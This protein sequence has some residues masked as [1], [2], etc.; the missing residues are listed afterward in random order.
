MSE[1]IGQP[2]L[3]ITLVGILAGREKLEVVG[4]FGDLLRQVGLWRRKSAVKVG[5]GFLL[6]MPPAGFELQVPSEL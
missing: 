4:I 5:N 1:V 6:P 2:A 3:K